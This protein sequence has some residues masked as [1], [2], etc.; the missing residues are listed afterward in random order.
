MVRATDRRGP[1]QSAK[2]VNRQGAAAAR[3][4]RCGSS[5]TA[6]RQILRGRTYLLTRRC[7]GRMFLL[8]PSNLTNEVFQYILAVAAGRT[9]ILIHAFCVLSNHFHAVVTDP[10]GNLPVFEQYL[11]SLVARSLNALLGR[12]ESFWAPGSY[13]AVALVEPKDILDK[14]AYVLANPTAAGLVRH[15]SE[16]PGLWSSPG[17]IGAGSV[18]VK[19]PEHFF[20]AKGPMPETAELELTCPPGFDSVAE[21]RRQLASDVKVLEDE[22]ARALGK[23]GRAFLGA[24]KAKVQ[25]PEARPAGAEPRR[26]LNPRIACR[27]RWKRAEALQRLESFLEAYREAWRKYADGARDMLFPRGTYWMKVAHGVRCSASG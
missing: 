24:R 23:E 27:D 5:M 1:G 16:W 21:L 15:G 6:P 2:S 18:T 4:L 8:R 12:W 14:M 3:F 25:R 22:A 9:G 10:R 20:R 11:D 7:F 19:K 17:R 26:G 13:S